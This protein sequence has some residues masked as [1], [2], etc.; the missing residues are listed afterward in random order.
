MR[1]SF[2]ITASESRETTRR[3]AKH[4]KA[5]LTGVMSDVG[6]EWGLE[7]ERNPI[8]GHE[9]HFTDSLVLLIEG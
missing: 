3:R 4:E 8:A 5:I 1:E 7:M 2:T 9:N 6:P